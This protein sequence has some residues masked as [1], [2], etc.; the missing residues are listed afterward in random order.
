MSTYRS[1]LKKE[2]D[3]PSG[4]RVTISKMNA[5]NMPV[6]E[7]RV[8]ESNEEQGYRMTRMILIDKTGPIDGLKIVDSV[9]DEK[10]QIGVN[11]IEQADIN[12]IVDAVLDFSGM[13]KRGEEARKTFP[14]ASA[15][16]SQCASAGSG[17]PGTPTDTVAGAP[18]GRV[19]AVA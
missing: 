1:R 14:E 12:C 11:E 2:I 17:L 13:T 5:L 6:L 18:D 9:T 4:H 3:L 15:N 8:A 10:T 16:G 19:V 7:K